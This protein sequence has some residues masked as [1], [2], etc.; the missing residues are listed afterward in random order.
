MAG[1]S[2]AADKLDLHAIMARSGHPRP[3]HACHRGG[4]MSFAY[5]WS[6]VNKSLEGEQLVDKIVAQHLEERSGMIRHFSVTEVW[7]LLTSC[8]RL[9]FFWLPSPGAAP[10]V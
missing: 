1:G 2:Y 3:L 7:C 10:L 8:I 9:H 4:G 5:P 6:S